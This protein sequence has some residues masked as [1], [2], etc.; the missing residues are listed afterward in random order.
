MEASVLKR[1]AVTSVGAAAIV[2]VFMIILACMSLVAVELNRYNADVKRSND[3]VVAKARENLMVT[4]LRGQ[5]NVTNEGSMPSVIIGFFHV[6]QAG[7]SHNYTRLR[8]PVAVPLLS[9][10]QLDVP[11]NCRV[12][13][14]TSLGNVF[15]ETPKRGWQLPWMT[16][17]YRKS[18]VIVGST[19]GAVADYQVRVT[20]HYEDG[21]DNGEHVYLGGKCRADFGDVRFTAGD[22]STLLDYWMEERADFG[23]A[24]FWVK[25]PNIPAYPGEAAIYVYY[26]NEA[27]G[28]TS[29]GDAVFLFFDDFLGST[30]DPN[31]WTVD[32]GITYSVVNGRLVVADLSTAQWNVRYGFHHSPMPVQGGFKLRVK[33]LG[34]SCASKGD[35]PMWRWGVVLADTAGY[36]YQMSAIWEDEF[37]GND[38]KNRLLRVGNAYLSTTIRT[39]GETVADVEFVKDQSGA[40]RVVFTDT[41]GPYPDSAT[42]T[43]IVLLVNKYSTSY[44]YADCTWVDA[45]IVQSYVS[46]EPSHGAWG[47]EETF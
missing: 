16:W 5:V 11:D 39:N 19:A 35:D 36:D 10:V 32:S 13:V 21:V 4:R 43:D 30:L 9:S 44:P 34:W 38:K 42:L 27:A 6:D 12:G 28:T 46:P 7:N 15:W 22:G 18:H 25:V 45:V 1:R 14:V 20:V 31:K 47:A 24:V 23:Y 26:G 17:S 41:L 8:N 29:N 2:A 40:C 37:R 3:L 33:G